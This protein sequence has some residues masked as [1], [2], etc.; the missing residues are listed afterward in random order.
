M[1][2]SVKLTPLLSRAMN[3]RIQALPPHHHQLI[4]SLSTVASAK[5]ATAS[6]ADRLFKARL[7]ELPPTG[8]MTK[9]VC[10]IGPAT[11][12]VEN[13][14]ELVHYGMNVAR[15]NFS[16]AGDDYSYPEQCLERIR[17]APG[18]H[19]QLATGGATNEHAKFLPNNVRAILVDTKGPEIRTGPLQGGVDVA[20]IAV[21]D[22]VDLTTRSVS[23]DPAPEDGHHVIQVDYQSIAKSLEPG[24]QAL[25]DDGLIA[26]EVVEVDPSSE[27]VTCVALNGG[28]IKKNKGVNLPNTVLDLPALTEKDKRDLKWACVVGADFVAASFIRT[29]ANVRSVVAYLDRCISELPREVDAPAPRRPLVISKIESKEGVDN[30]DEILEASD[31]IMVARGD[32]GVE[33]PYSKVFAAQKMMVNKCNRLGR[34]VIVA[35]QML[36]SM[37]TRPRPTRAEVTDVGTAI[38]DGTD[39]TMLSGET[40]AGNYPI[41]SLRSMASIVHESDSIRDDTSEVLWNEELHA[42]MP[43]EEQELDVV[44]AAAVRSAKDMGAKSIILITQSGRVARAVARHQPAV[45]VLSFCTDV[46]VARRLQLHRALVPLLLQSNLDPKCATTRLGTLRAEAV[47][48]AKELGFIQNG[49]RIIMVDQTKGKSGDHHRY[50]HNLKVVTI[51]SDNLSEL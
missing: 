10:T 42:T 25:L 48:T 7:N 29:A 22:R 47:R 5:N 6:S 31:G 13:I 8:C 30:F 45:P 11:D 21:G 27:T 16:H 33:I 38:L 46:Q 17:N 32:L 23:S 15:L 4:A 3:T 41:E 34:S 14:N 24:K 19:F 2:R 39:A 20:E 28:P 37:Q 51:Q 49:E 1:F 40:A 12:S 36:D 50:A 35:T 44:A 43:P 26:L 9:L 18:K